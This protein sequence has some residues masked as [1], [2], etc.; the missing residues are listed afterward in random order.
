MR[1]VLLVASRCLFFTA[2]NG[3]YKRI[4]YVAI[5][6]ANTDIETAQLN[7]SEIIHFA[8]TLVKTDKN[9]SFQIIFGKLKRVVN[10]FEL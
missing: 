10:S 3:S 6:D 2:T 1:A 8:Q 9:C 7:S 5:Y 4:R